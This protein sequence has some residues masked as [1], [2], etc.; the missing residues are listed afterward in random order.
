MQ[1][2][3]FYFETTG[4]P[5]VLKF[6]PVDV[7]PLKD[8]DVVVR[9]TA[10]GVNFMDIYQRK[11]T[12]PVNLPSGIGSEAAGV[13]QAVGPAVVD[14]KV[15]DRVAYMDGAPGSYAD[16]RVLPADRLLKLPDFL[17]DEDAAAL[18]LKGMT[19]EY[20]FERCAPLERG[21]FALIY[22]AAGGVGMIAGQWAR[23]RGVNLIGVT[24]GGAK[25]RLAE[26]AGYFAVIDRN[27]EDVQEQ[28]KAITGGSGVSAVYDA[29]GKATFE[30]SLKSLAPRGIFVSF[31]AITGPAPPVD[32]GVLMRGG[33]LY[34]TRPTLMTYTASREDFRSSAAAVI[35]KFESG[36]ITSTIGQRYPLREAVQAQS[37]L[38]GGAT[39]G[40]SIL[41]P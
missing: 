13:I 8:R 36:A 35:A 34:F 12:F 7:P 11:G 37:D 27:K 23:A 21:K 10:I 28:V 24:S 5:E 31:G 26:D 38:E 20:L 1:A 18:L 29:V 22:G 6:G 2:Q 14:L 19:V 16:V 39:S 41:I 3:R 25:R 15:G 17:S 32:P 9:H 33:S 30:T 40:S 4:G